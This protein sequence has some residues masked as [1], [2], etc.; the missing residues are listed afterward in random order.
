MVDIAQLSFISALIIILHHWAIHPELTGLNRFVQVSD[1]DSH[2][3]WALGFIAFG[4][5]VFVGM[6]T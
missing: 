5:A 1:I 6:R 2:E 3:V 4:T